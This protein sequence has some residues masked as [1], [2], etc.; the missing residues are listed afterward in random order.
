MGLIGDLWEKVKINFQAC[1]NLH[2]NIRA[3]SRESRTA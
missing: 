3:G 1:P 2:N